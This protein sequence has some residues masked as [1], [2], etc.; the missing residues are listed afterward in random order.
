MSLPR[1]LGLRFVNVLGRNGQIGEDGHVVTG[2]FD[3]PPAYG[4]KSMIYEMA[5]DRS[6]P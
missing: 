2:D 4:Q 5:L 1:F 6:L 3:E